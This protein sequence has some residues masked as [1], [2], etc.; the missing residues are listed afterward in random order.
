M[1]AANPVLPCVLVVED[2]PVNLELIVALLEANGCRVVTAT[3]A[4]EGVRLAGRERPGLILMD[5]QLPGRT[6]HDAAR[7]LKAESATATIPIVAVTA[8]A[9]LG[10]RE[11]ALA[12][13]CDDYCTKPLDAERFRE[14]VH[15]YLSTTSR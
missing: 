14:I 12:A 3:T 9:M 7:Q 15:R 2:N 4:D 6:G 8:Q 10:D 1:E 5:V 13:G 11:R